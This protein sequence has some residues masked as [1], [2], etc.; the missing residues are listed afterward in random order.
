M[1]DLSNVSTSVPWEKAICETGVE[2][3]L[4]RTFIYLSPPVAIIIKLSLL[5]FIAFADSPDS[6][7]DLS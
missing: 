7:L 2:I 1:A 3:E 6:F 4:K 5:K